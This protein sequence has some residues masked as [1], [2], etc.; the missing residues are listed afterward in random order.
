MLTGNTFGPLLALKSCIPTSTS[1]AELPF[2]VP[3]PAFKKKKKV[4]WGSHTIHQ[5]FK[6]MT[7][8]ANAL[9]DIYGCN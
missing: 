6:C 3:I 2:L 7:L 5:N 4:C 8:I 1:V 9:L